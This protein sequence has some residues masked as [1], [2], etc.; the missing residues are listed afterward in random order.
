MKLFII[1]VSK[2]EI[3]I[4]ISFCIIFL[5]V[6]VISTYGNRIKF[7]TY[8]YSIKCSFSNNADI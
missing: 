3:V 7:I 1:G 5:S 8:F 6:Y 4:R 2:V